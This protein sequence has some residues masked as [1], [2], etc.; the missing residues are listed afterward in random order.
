MAAAA[1]SE[2][3]CGAM[4]SVEPSVPGSTGRG[5]CG[6]ECGWGHAQEAHARRGPVSCALNSAILCHP[7]HSIWLVI[8]CQ[9][10]ARQRPRM[11]FQ[12][13]SRPGPRTRNLREHARSSKAPCRVIDC[14]LICKGPLQSRLGWRQTAKEEG[15][16]SKGCQQSGVWISKLAQLCSGR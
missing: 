2:D 11:H 9:A 8:G 7:G 15:W 12:G 14:L 5:R 3:H 1:W 4:A 13:K 16:L 10:M 6:R